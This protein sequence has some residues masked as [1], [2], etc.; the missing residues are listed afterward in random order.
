MGGYQVFDFDGTIYDGDSSKDFFLFVIK[1]YPQVLLMIPRFSWHGVLYLSKR[2]SKERMK[3]SYFSFLRYIPDLPETLRLFWLEYEEKIYKWYR[4]RNHAGDVVI[5]ASPDFLVRSALEQFGVY[6]V[7]GTKVDCYTGKFLSKNCYG[8]EKVYRFQEALGNV[9]ITEFY[10]DSISDLPMA[11][12]AKQAYF[13][14]RGE[15][16]Q[17]KVPR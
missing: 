13:V 14:V 5:S 1:R 3:E 12:L 4:H 7:I 15:I 17:W 16:K 9:E 2:C 11:R 8:Q 6:A 10:S